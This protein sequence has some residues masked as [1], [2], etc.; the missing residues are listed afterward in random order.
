[1]FKYQLHGSNVID[2][3]LTT[4]QTYWFIIF[5]IKLVFIYIKIND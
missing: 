4:R 2:I 5:F 3:I 1:M